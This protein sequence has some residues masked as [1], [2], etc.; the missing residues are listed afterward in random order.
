MALR[1]NRK[2]VLLTLGIGAGIFA[3]G[4]SNRTAFNATKKVTDLSTLG[5]DGKDFKSFRLRQIM[6]Y[7][8]N[9]SL[10]VFDLPDPNASA[11]LPVASFLLAKADIDGKEVIRPY[12]P[13]DSHVTGAIHLLVKK[14][15]EGKLSKHFHNLKPGQELL[16][17]G[18]TTKIKYVPNMKKEIGMIAGGTGITPM[19]QVINEIAS[20]P[21]DKTKVTLL[22]ANLTPEDILLKERL[23]DIQKKN[24]NIKVH[25]TVDKPNSS[26]KGI[27]GLVTEDM[28]KSYLPA[29]TNKD[30]MIFVCGPPGMMQSISGPKA[31]D[32]SQ[33]K[34]TGILLKMKYTEDQVFKF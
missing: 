15:E 8:H 17:K 25:Y 6:K 28:I 22:F 21:M 26:W 23:D 31:P 27:K 29:P 7:N 2:T 10:F 12:T 20:N 9:T 5:L 24:S 16:L 1:L 18:P 14:Y 4:Y 32:Y 34:L 30:A 3:A 19:L 11:E 13:I 33:G